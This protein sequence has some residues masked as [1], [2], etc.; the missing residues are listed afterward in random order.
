MTIGVDRGFIRGSMWPHGLADR[1]SGSLRLARSVLIADGDSDL[2]RTIRDHVQS[3]GSAAWEAANG[4]EA[5]W[6]VK[7]HRPAVALL[8]LTMPRL[9]GLETQRH[10]R[11]FDPS[12]RVVVVTDDR[13]EETR[14]RIAGLGLELL[15]TPLAPEA[16]ETLLG[17]TDPAD[18]PRPSTC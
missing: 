16:L 2:R 3:T 14:Q 9:D 1:A 11:R 10:I 8:G 5:L 12:I 6:V 18:V 15:L 7:H 13:S 17:P 4:L